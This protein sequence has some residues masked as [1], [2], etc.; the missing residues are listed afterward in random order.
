MLGAETGA[1]GLVV[2]SNKN[3]I[4]GREKVG[5]PEHITHH[6]EKLTVPLK[7]VSKLKAGDEV[8]LSGKIYTAR[9]KAHKHLLENGAELNLNVIYH[10]GPLINGEEIIGA[11]PTTS[12]RM[13]LYEEDVIKKYGVKAVIG[14]GRMDSSIFKNTR[15]VYLA[16]VGG[17]AVLL[18]KSIKGWK[19]VVDLGPVDSIYELEVVDFPAVV[20]IDS[21][22][23]SLFQR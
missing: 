9:D 12:A 8:L 11:G 18:A 5:E 1:V 13:G 6:E 14:K 23:E 2:M 22:G 17:A 15:T 4:E 19:R 20:G 7:D 3:Q 16:A 10:C 21:S